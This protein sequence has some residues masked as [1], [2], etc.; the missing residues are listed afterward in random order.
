MKSTTALSKGLSPQ[1]IRA[2]AIL[3]M[4]NASLIAYLRYHDNPCLQSGRLPPPPV[5]E[6]D[7]R[8][9]LREANHYTPAEHR[10]RVAWLIDC[11]TDE[12]YLSLPDDWAE[13]EWETSV[14]LL[15]QLGEPGIGAR[16]VRECLLLQLANR[17]DTPARRTAETLVRRHFQWLVRKRWDRLPKHG[18]TDG[19]QLLETLSPRPPTGGAAA[20][21]PPI[22]P[23]IFC[24]E[25]RGL[26]KVSGG[27]APAPFYQPNSDATGKERNE[28]RQIVTAVRAR[29][30]WL[31]RL[32]RYVVDRQAEFLSQGGAMRQLTMVEAAKHFG[33]SPAM[34]SHVAH[35]KFI[36]S[37]RGIFPLKSLFPRHSRT[38][39]LRRRIQ[40]L[41]SG[42]NPHRPLSDVALGEVLR[43]GGVQVTARA[44]GKQRQLLGFPPAHLRKR[45]GK[46]VPILSQTENQHEHRYYRTSN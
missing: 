12:G 38:I 7:F 25:Q 6:G 23:D 28:A 5:A 10:Q 11:L 21:Q 17:P 33:M 15:Q 18:L 35:E 13:E 8:E 20:T 39:E 2:S 36:A 24:Q 1:L 37:P 42:E 19:L 32:G 45:P 43:R 14:A 46:N 30:H 29:Q 27:V 34:I 9:D 22:F 31:L 4:S 16:N 41:I 3:R 44:I 40:D 26:W